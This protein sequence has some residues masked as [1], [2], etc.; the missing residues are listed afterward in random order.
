MR[1]CIWKSQNNI[2]KWKKQAASFK[3]VEY[4]IDTYDQADQ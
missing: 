4:N 1:K 2:K 3:N